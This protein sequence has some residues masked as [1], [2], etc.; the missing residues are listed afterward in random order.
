MIEMRE[1]DLTKETDLTKEIESDNI[2]E[3]IEFLDIYTGK[4]E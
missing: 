1:I 3:F 2:M 4:E